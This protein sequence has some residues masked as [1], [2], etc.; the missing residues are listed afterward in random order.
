[1]HFCEIWKNK[2]IK[3]KHMHEKVDL[4]ENALL[5]IL[6]WNSAAKLPVLKNGTHIGFWLLLIFM[7]DN[8]HKS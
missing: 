7:L 8:F 3:L 5:V 6:K 2:W 1:M 4:S